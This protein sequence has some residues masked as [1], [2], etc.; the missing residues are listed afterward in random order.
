MTTLGAIV[1]A[2][3][4]TL[5][6]HTWRNPSTWDARMLTVLSEWG[7]QPSEVE[8]LLLPQPERDA[9]QDADEE[10]DDAVEAEDDSAEQD[11]AEHSA[12]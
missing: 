9:E 4:A 5:G 8:S 7:Y 6:K 1:T 3:E 11:S 12:A 10:S 2:W